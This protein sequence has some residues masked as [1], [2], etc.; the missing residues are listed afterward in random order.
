MREFFTPCYV[1]LI[2]NVLKYPHNTKDLEATLSKLPKDK[3]H[4]LRNNLS[5][6]NFNLNP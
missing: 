4:L 3:K 5:V 2:E 6:S 1:V